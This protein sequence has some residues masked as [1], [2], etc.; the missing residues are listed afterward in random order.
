MEGYGND[1]L[2][3]WSSECEKHNQEKEFFQMVAGTDLRTAYYMD[4][5][6]ARF[7]S[8]SFTK[9]SV[10]NIESGFPGPEIYNSS[11]ILKYCSLTFF[12]YYFF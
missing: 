2:L 4:S 12:N 10:M 7:N 1:L 5:C 8:K 3:Y 9:L 11:R 6:M